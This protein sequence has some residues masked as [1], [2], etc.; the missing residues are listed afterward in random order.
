MLKLSLVHIFPVFLFRKLFC[1]TYYFLFFML[2]PKGGYKRYLHP[3]CGKQL[4]DYIGITEPWLEPPPPLWKYLN[5]PLD[6]LNQY[7]NRV[8]YEHL[9]LRYFRYFISLIVVIKPLNVTTIALRFIPV[10]L[11]TNKTRRFHWQT[12]YKSTYYYV[13]VTILIA[14]Y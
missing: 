1:Y 8:I 14:D 12:F 2:G 11:M 7:C 4:V 3:F 10:L 9:F 6:C 13:L 5:P